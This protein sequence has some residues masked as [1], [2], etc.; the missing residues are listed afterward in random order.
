MLAGQWILRLGQLVVDALE[1]RAV[2]GANAAHGLLGR[3]DHASRSDDLHF[4][5]A[6]AEAMRRI[7]IEM[8]A[9]K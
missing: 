6:A 1:P 9:Q 4:F 7:L 2:H 3:L 8:P 5:A